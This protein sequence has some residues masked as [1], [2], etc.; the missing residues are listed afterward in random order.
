MAAPGALERI[1]VVVGLICSFNPDQAI[2][3]LASRARWQRRSFRFRFLDHFDII[4]KQ[5]T[6]VFKTG[7]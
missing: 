7:L 2:R 6:P 1:E 3:Q 4:S 5:A